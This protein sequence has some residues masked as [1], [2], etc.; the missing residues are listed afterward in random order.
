MFLES[1][2]D[3]CESFSINN[4]N[5]FVIPQVNSNFIEDVLICQKNHATIANEEVLQGETLNTFLN[6]CRNTFAK[7]DIFGVKISF[8]RNLTSFFYVTSLKKTPKLYNSLD[9]VRGYPLCK[10][11]EN[12]CSSS[13]VAILTSFLILTSL[14]TVL[15]VAVAYKKKVCALHLQNI[16]VFKV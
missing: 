7:K 6:D 10:K 4:E 15:V 9:E 16:K 11:N 14:I 1:K 3:S 13:S 2:E 12:T 8:L 5:Y